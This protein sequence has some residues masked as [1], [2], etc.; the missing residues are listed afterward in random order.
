MVSFALITLVVAG[1]AVAS[2]L[3][4]G[5]TAI[6]YRT[7]FQLVVNVTE[8]SQDF[9]DTPVHGLRLTGIRTSDRSFEPTVDKS[10][11]TF[12]ADFDAILMAI[13]G[14]DPYGISYDETTTDPLKSLEINAS[15][16]SEGLRIYVP[17]DAKIC[18]KLSGPP[19]LAGSYIVCDHGFAAPG[20]ARLQVEY[21]ASSEGAPFKLP[22]GCIAVNLLPECSHLD[23]HK[24][25]YPHDPVKT[26]CHTTKVAGIDWSQQP[27]C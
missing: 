20:S 7:G 3:T 23:F 21:M 5:S 10:G 14:E 13:A 17:D 26:A 8:P 9:K 15:L 12:Y 1:F 4:T 16:G 6:A 2:P 22:K 19:G 27:R 11:F 24:A 18:A 25:S